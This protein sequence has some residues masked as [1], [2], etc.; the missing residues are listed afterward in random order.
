MK[1]HWAT[2]GWFIRGL[3]LM[4]LDEGGG[5]CEEGGKTWSLSSIMV[6][7]PTSNADRRQMVIFNTAIANKTIWFSMENWFVHSIARIQFIFL[8][9]C[10][11]SF[12][13]KKSK[14]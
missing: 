5:G 9:V 14:N 13:E 8:E 7:F 12:I 10:S 11:F 1:A 3:S 4:S 2:A 6:N